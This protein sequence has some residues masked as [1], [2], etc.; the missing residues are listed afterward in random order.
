[1]TYVVH[2][3]LLG[4]IHFVLLVQYWAE[5]PSIFTASVDSNAFVLATAAIICLFDEG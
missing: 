5:L 4:V 2:V 1:V 3:N